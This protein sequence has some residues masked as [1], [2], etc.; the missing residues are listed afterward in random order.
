M[1]A[2]SYDGVSLQTDNIFTANIDHS[3][4]RIS[5]NKHEI[6][7]ANRSKFDTPDYPDRTVVI[8]GSFNADTITLA[9]EL[10]D[11][12]RGLFVGENKYLDIEYA[13]ATR[14]YIA[15]PGMVDIRRPGGLMYGTF[16]V[17]FDCPVPFGIDTTLTELA[18]VDAHTASTLSIPVTIGG[19][20]DEQ[21][22]IISVLVVSGSGMTPGTISVGNGLNG[23]V[24]EVERSWIEGEI[25]LIDPFEQTVKV[26]ANEVA[27]T[28]SIPLFNKGSGSV[29]YA[30]TFVSRE[31]D[32]DINQYRYW[33]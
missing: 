27:F 23:Q 17:Q 25:L 14:R 21:Y 12:L 32:I 28:G 20:A 13:G 2:I 1:T 26:G 16:T 7:N 19:T 3:F 30:D 11:T 10:E 5:L 31:V 8:Q 9:D 6:A 22:P 33:M 4:P 15:T 24:L 18:D 29:T